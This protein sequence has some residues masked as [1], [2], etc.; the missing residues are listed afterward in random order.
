MFFVCNSM[1]S[2]SLS[3]VGKSCFHCLVKDL[4]VISSISHPPKNL[5]LPAP[6]KRMSIC[7]HGT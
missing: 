2:Y 6:L 5:N 1:P 3:F 7:K 4:L